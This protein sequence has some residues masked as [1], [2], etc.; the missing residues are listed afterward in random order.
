M[1]K[2]VLVARFARGFSSIPTRV[3]AATNAGATGAA[4]GGEAGV[5]VTVGVGILVAVGVLA[6][7]DVAEGVGVRDRVGEAVAVLEGSSGVAVSSARASCSWTPA[8]GGSGFSAAK[9]RGIAPP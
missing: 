6:V 3:L 9:A 1:K 4:G 5:G 8:G 7:V 2:V